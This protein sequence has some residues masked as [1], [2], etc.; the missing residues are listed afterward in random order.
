LNSNLNTLPYDF[1]LIFTSTDTYF[2]VKI[3]FLQE[4]DV[5]T[6][7]ERMNAM[8]VRQIFTHRNIYLFGLSL[9]LVTLPTSRYLMSIAQFILIFNWLFDR[10]LLSKFR[11]FFKNKPALV[12]FSVFLIHVIG[13]LWTTDFQYALKDLR[14]KLPL[15]ALPIIISTT[16]PLGK[17]DFFN[18][19][20]LYVAANLFGT[21]FSLG[22][23]LTDDVFNIRNISVFISHIRFALNLALAFF[24]SIYLFFQNDYLFP[25][26][27]WLF[28]VSGLW[29]LTF[30]ILME[31]VTGLSVVLITAFVLLMVYFFRTRNFWHK[32]T[33]IVIL[34]VIPVALAL[35]LRSLYHEVIPDEPFYHER[36]DKLTRQGNPY[37]HDSTLTGVE[38]GHWV[39]QYIEM[40]ELKA[41][42][43]KRSRIPFEGFDEKGN[44]VRFTLMRYLTS[45]GLRKDADGVMALTDDDVRAVEM[46]FANKD[47]LIESSLKRR[48][49][50]VI[51]E[52]EIYRQ[53]GCL[54]GNSVTQRLE[55]WRAGLQIIRENF[56]IG[57]GTG[58]IDNAFKAMYPKIKSQL[59]PEQWWRTH[60]QYLTVF[61][62][63]GLFGFLWFIFALI[64]P[65][66]K[67]NMFSN[68]FYLVFFVIGA[69][70]M[71]TG[72][73]LDTQAGVTFWAFFTMFFLFNGE[74]NAPSRNQKQLRLKIFQHGQ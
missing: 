11:N 57:V 28:L 27:R 64:Y 50:T 25:R 56:W 74:E 65:G 34:I 59:P 8:N 51:W 55:F 35:Y 23:L 26:L 54:S 71:I 47:H 5:F 1:P 49:K 40:D 72:D 13:L 43:K 16:P 32:F 24:V 38:N 67:L 69:L 62:T 41:G 4:K 12:I 9:M 17:K 63:L 2:A 21:F 61:A 33:V 68:Y 58:D 29:L 31:S 44:P 14:I 15:L 52:L 60:N 19:M 22:K 36:L 39:G 7:T 30:L 66:L 42:W 45:K 6:F 53:T 48:I 70:S 20:T 37:F 46:G 18:L 10:K 73:T 3:V